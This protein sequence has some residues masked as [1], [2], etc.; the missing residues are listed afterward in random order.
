MMASILFYRELF[1]ITFDEEGARLS[2]MPVSR[3]NFLFTLL[4]AV[5]VSVSARTVGALVVSSLMVL[6]VAVAIQL[7]KSYRQTVGYSV[8]FGVC[9]TG[10]GLFLSYYLNL[11]P[12]GTI[13]L[14][15]VATLLIVLLGKAWL[16]LSK[17]DR[18]AT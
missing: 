17:A 10:I 4:T 6:P 3:V 5:T 8:L 7:A 16:N 12:G 1:Y 11:K 2:G 15:G 13:V 18:R 9:F 14:V